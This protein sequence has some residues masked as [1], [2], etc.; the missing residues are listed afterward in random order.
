MSSTLLLGLV[1]VVGAPAPKDK[2]DPSRIEGDWKLTEYI[3]AGR[4]EPERTGIVFRIGDGKFLTIGQKE[5]VD[6]N[7][8][9]KT[10]PPSIDLLPPKNV[11]E[12]IILGIYKVDGDTLTICFT[13]GAGADR[14]KKFESP[15]DAKIVLMKLKRVKKD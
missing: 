4:E 3:Q 15:A 6:Y 2:V 14:P 11:K 9:A 12:G 13:K 7:L 8:D 10:D 5:Q 1:V